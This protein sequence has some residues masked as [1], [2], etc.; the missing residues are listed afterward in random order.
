MPI[1][2]GEINK[3]I[4]REIRNDRQMHE[5]FETDDWYWS[6]KLGVPFSSPISRLGERLKNKL[7]RRW[8]NDK[9]RHRK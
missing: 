2:L 3:L 9:I 7:S 5:I 1:S 8:G 4:D 6:K